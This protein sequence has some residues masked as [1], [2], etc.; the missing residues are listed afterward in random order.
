MATVNKDALIKHVA[1]TSGLKRK[2][3]EAAVNALFAG[4]EN[5]IREGHDVEVVGYMRAS[6]TL[7]QSRIARNPQNGDL[8]EVPAHYKLKLRPMTKLKIAASDIGE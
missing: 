7:V 8:V 1:V 2:D 3:A 5:A 4:I 6:T